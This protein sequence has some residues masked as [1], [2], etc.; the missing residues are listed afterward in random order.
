MKRDAVT[1]T[2]RAGLAAAALW[3]GAPAA[4]A[5]AASAS[6]EEEDDEPVPAPRALREAVGRWEAAMASGDAARIGEVY[7]PE[8]WL[9]P[10]CAPMQVGRPALAEAWREIL[11]YSPAN[12]SLTPRSFDMARGRDMASE[13]GRA[14]FLQIVG[15]L[16]YG[17]NVDYLRV[18]RRRGGTWLIVADLFTPG[19]PCAD[20]D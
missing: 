7:A 6:V 11:S 5:A 3:I 2:V 16:P 8:A 19:G 12:L 17:T 15:G 10:P 20:E 18:W 13:R 14:Q 1:N 9:K 4:A